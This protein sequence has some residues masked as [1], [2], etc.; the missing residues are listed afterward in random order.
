MPIHTSKTCSKHQ[1]KESCMTTSTPGG[2]CVTTSKT[3]YDDLRKTCEKFSSPE[4]NLNDLKLGLQQLG[5]L[6]NCRTTWPTSEFYDQ[7]EKI[8]GCHLGNLEFK[9][10]ACIIPVRRNTMRAHGSVLRHLGVVTSKHILLLE[11]LPCAFNLL[12]WPFRQHKHWDLSRARSETRHSQKI[13]PSALNGGSC[14]QRY[15]ARI[16]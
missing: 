2:K 1:L 10:K 9:T 11:K 12:V 14:S 3:M 16:W 15:I 5:Q 7:L 13:P 6:G 4:N 8:A